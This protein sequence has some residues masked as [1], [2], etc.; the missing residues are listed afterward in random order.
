MEHQLLNKILEDPDDLQ[1]LL[2]EEV[3]AHIEDASFYYEYGSER[4]MHKEYDYFLSPEAVTVRFKP[5][6]IGRLFYLPNIMSF[7]PQNMVRPHTLREGKV[8]TVEAVL[9]AV[10]LVEEGGKKYIQATYALGFS[11]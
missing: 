11:D 7:R 1:A 4:G 8:M 9:K 6:S 2:E 3:T 10:T 5:S